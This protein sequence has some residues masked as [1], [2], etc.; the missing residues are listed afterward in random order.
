MT[1][2]RDITCQKQEE[3]RRKQLEE[4][5]R[6]AHKME[7][8]GA[9][10]GGA[11]HEFNNIL[12]I[13][14]AYTELAKTDLGRAEPARAHLNEVLK[15]AQRATEII[16][17][18]LAFSRQQ[19]QPREL[20]DLR[21]VVLEAVALIRTALP[22]SIR[23]ETE[24]EPS[25]AA[26][27]GNSTQIHQVVMNICAN[28]RHAMDE[29]GGII[30]VALQIIHLDRT[31]PEIH[32][33]LREGSYR[34]LSI[35]DNGAGM[36]A[37]TLAR[38]FEPFFTTKSPGKGSGLGLSV[39]HGIMQAHDGAVTV[40]S[41]PGKGTDFD[42]YFPARLESVPERKAAD[43][44][45]IPEGQNRRILVVDDETSLARATT[46]QLCRFGYKATETH[47]AEDALAAL[48]AA[49]EPFDLVITD[50]TMPGMS[51]LDLARILHES[52]PSLPVILATGFDGAQASANAR[53][54]NV[55]AL[56]QKPAAPEILARL[57]HTILGPR[58]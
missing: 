24:I 49:P 8:L 16:Q 36:D 42:L 55:R 45:P 32:H 41:E 47:A 54:P 13:I 5:L 33:T 35:V 20:I 29:R 53:P 31:A 50:L 27:L 30:R 14:I 15:A 23:I 2:V 18:I 9:L 3:R 6:E 46:E 10:A 40:R 21:A 37:A 44:S 51:G 11:A 38:I 17:Q 26:I 57:I 56:L 4:Q 1:A 34:R 58:H 28:A 43:E 25:S 52:H 22:G 12:G 7:A 48:G 39:V 19:Q